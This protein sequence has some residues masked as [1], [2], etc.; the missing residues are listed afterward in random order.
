VALHDQLHLAAERDGEKIALVCDD[1][2]LT[3]SELAT[4]TD[5]VAS[6]LQHHGVRPGDRVVVY[7]PNSVDAVVSIYGIWRAGGCLVMADGDSTAD[8]L[9]YRV[10][11]SGATVLI[12]PHSRGDVVRAALAQLSSPP[13]VIV[14]GEP[15]AGESIPDAVPLPSGDANT[16][17]PPKIDPHAPA[18]IIYTSGSTGLPKGVTHSQHSISTVV[19]AVGDYLEH[20]PDDVVLCVLQLA[21]GYGLLQLLV[22]FDRR[23]RVVLRRGFG[24]PFDLVT[25]MAAERVTGLA[26]VPTLFAL[27]RELRDSTLA[28]ASSLRYL[29]NAAAALPPAQIERVCAMFPGA[30]LFVMHGQT[31]CLRTTHLP[32][33]QLDERPTSVGRGMAGVELWLENEA[34]ERLPYPGQGELVVRGENVMLGYWHDQEATAAVVS[35]GRTPHERTLHTRDLFRTDDDGYFHFVSRTDDI[36][37]TR[38]EK[39]SPTEIEHRL[40][41]RAE[42][43]EARVIGVP[44]DLLGQAIRAEVVLRPGHSLSEEELRK[45]LRVSLEPYKM[46]KTIV[47]VDSLPKS[48]S[49]KV[50]RIP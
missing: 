34:G 12:A 36:I 19:A 4:A 3:Y 16:F 1:R 45:Y 32:S 7:L 17:S 31:E 25:T 26:G 20:S 49:G 33:D 14:A 10:M 43:S 24:L 44:D 15:V 35:P 37:K 46:P 5:R 2:R 23:G 48:T 6:L 28:A 42:I 47:F 8:N 18:A 30:K 22:T 40:A 50:L 13:V 11:H 21:F 9:A 29:T 27:L 41:L 38:G 39:V